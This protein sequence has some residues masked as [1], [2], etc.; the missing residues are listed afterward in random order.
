MSAV[1]IC[2]CL[3]FSVSA[4]TFFSARRLAFRHLVRENGTFPAPRTKGPFWVGPCRRNTT[5]VTLQQETPTSRNVAAVSHRGIC[6]HFH[7]G[8][9]HALAMSMREGNLFPLLNQIDRVVFMYLLCVQVCAHA[10]S[11]PLLALHR[12]LAVLQPRPLS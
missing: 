8:S 5:R 7:L 12:S 9:Q 3:C 4:R 2:G 11:A 10:L 6:F 1:F